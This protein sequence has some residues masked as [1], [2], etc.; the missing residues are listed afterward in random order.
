MRLGRVVLEEP[1]LGEVRL[2][3][4]L[5]RLGEVRLG[6]VVLELLLGLVALGCTRV[7]LRSMRL[8]PELERELPLVVGVERAAAAL[9]VV[10]LVRAER[11]RSA[12]LVALLPR[13]ATDAT[14]GACV[15][16][17]WRTTRGAIEVVPVLGAVTRARCVLF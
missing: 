11:T 16:L 12:P 2:G 3:L 15:R 9:L 4:T 7:R 10:R 5:P 1:R 13:A 17:V 8:L 6:V 14:G